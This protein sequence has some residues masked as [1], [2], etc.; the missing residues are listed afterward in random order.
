M[1]IIIRAVGM[2]V[3]FISTLVA[4]TDDLIAYP[5]AK[6]VIENKI[7]TDEFRLQSLSFKLTCIMDNTTLQLVNI[8]KP[9]VFQVCAC[10]F[11]AYTSCAI[12]KDF[13]IFFIF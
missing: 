7:F 11:A 8:F 4:H 13:L 9:F 5:F 1:A 10:L 3:G 2:C 12:Q 6:P